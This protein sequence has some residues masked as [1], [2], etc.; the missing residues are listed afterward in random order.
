[1][2]FYIEQQHYSRICNIL[3][4]IYKFSEFLNQKNLQKILQ[5][6]GKQISFL[7][8][9]ANPKS[10]LEPFI[11]CTSFENK[12]IL[13]SQELSSIFKQQFV[14]LYI[15]QAKILQQPGQK[16]RFCSF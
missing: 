12:R 1:M 11:Q 7:R 6:K 16:F 2:R 9:S 10:F 14:K 15:K 4:Y 3:L 5:F 8:S 13:A